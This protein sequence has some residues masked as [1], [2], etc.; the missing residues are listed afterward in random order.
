MG[1]FISF[2]HCVP[3]TVHVALASSG[4]VVLHLPSIQLI[5]IA[6]SSSCIAVDDS[7]RSLIPHPVVILCPLF[8]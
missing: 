1:N 4:S 3:P 6:G 7:P 2:V 5:G 8:G